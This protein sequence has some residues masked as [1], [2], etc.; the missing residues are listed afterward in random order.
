MADPFVV[1]VQVAARMGTPKGYVFVPKGN[2]KSSI[3]AL[4]RHT[5][6]A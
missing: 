1:E 5:K 4:D 2:D 6:Q 3:T